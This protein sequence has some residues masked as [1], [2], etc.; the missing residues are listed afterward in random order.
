MF[1]ISDKLL[2]LLCILLIFIFGI[3]IFKNIS[4]P[5]LWNDEAET[6]MFGKRILTYGYPKIHD[7]KNTL[8]SCKHPIENLASQ[9]SLDAYILSGWLQYYYSV[10]GVFLAQN[11]NSLYLKTAY[12]RIPFAIAGFIGILIL[13]IFL[14]K[15][16]KSFRNKILFLMLYIFFEL[17]S[18]PLALNIREVRYYSLAI[19]LSSCMFICYFKYHIFK[20]KSYISYLFWTIFIFLL[21][22][23]TF[24]PLFFIFFGTLFMDLMIKL[25][26]ERNRNFKEIIKLILP[27]LLSLI[28]VSPFLLFYKTIPI[29]NEMSKLW[30][31]NLIDY[32]NNINFV[33]NFFSKYDFLLFALVL[34]GIIIFISKHYK[35]IFKN[36]SFWQTSQISNLI[37]L[38]IVIYIFVIS[39]IPFIFERYFITLQS[40]LSI[41]I[42]I[43]LIKIIQLFSKK[44]IHKQ[45][46]YICWTLIIVIFTNSLFSRFDLLKGHIYELFHQYKGP[47]DYLVFYLKEKYQ[48]SE[49]LIIA[50][51]YEEPSLMYYLGSKVT[52]GFLGNSLDEDLKI[53]PD[54]IIIRKGW[55]DNQKPLLSLLGETSYKK[56]TFRILD[57]PV[58]N[59]PEFTFR[60]PHLFKTFL[61]DNSVQALEIFIKK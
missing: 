20:N 9:E 35:I 43:D 55:F 44:I 31:S 51:N 17:L 47:I 48:D 1:K 11:V 3:S 7:S 5:L 18:I 58:N 54:I 16:F 59:I 45:I 57:Y 56:I 36:Q 32:L 30:N 61:T 26:K 40:L 49:R 52:I 14:A 60:A 50:T 38:F 25:I 6:A 41:I 37:I 24:Y 2:I 46:M 4:Y 22:F 28:F 33:L 23:N 53:Q 29:A 10:P 42:V 21:I 13:G 8:Y 19:L 34:K 12:L 15:T 27:L 39:K